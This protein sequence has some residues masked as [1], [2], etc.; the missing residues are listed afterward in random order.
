MISEKNAP[1]LLG[2]AFLFVF[3]ASLVS[4]QMTSSVIGSGS[5][6]DMLVSV[7]SGGPLVSRTPADDGRSDTSCAQRSPS[8]LKN[9]SRSI[10]PLA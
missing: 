3:A 10:S 7:S 2:A 6:S 9:S 5:M 4:T 1:R 8:R